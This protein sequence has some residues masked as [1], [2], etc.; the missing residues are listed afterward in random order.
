MTNKL[1][2]HYAVDDYCNDCGE[3]IEEPYFTNDKNEIVHVSTVTAGYYY[4][5]G[6]VSCEACHDGNS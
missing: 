5:D 1:T 3:G 6:S 2:V 4:N